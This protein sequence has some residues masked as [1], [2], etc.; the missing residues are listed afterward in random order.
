MPIIFRPTFVS[1]SSDNCRTKEK[2]MSDEIETVVGRVLLSKE[3]NSLSQQLKLFI[4]VIENIYLMSAYYD[5]YETPSPKGKEDEPSLHARICPKVTY[6]QK[7]FVEHVATFQHLPKSVIGAALDACIDELCDLLADGNIVELGDLGFFSTSLKCLRETDDEKK[8]IRSESV[9]FQNVNLRISSTFRKKIRRAMTL[10]RVHS[11]TKKSKKIKSTEESRKEKLMLFL[12]K[13]ICI[14]KTEYIQLTGLTRHAAID[15]L[16]K[17]ISQGFLR[18]RGISR[19][20][21]YVKQEEETD[22]QDS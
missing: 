8:K 20:T 17:F 11:T 18:R 22:K 9:R 1:L 4:V 15:E 10:E 6:T 21:V 13:N 14:T 7:E 2:Q 16:N 5:L 19:S 12:Q 3:R